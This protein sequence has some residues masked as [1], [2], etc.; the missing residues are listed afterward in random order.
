[1]V[2]TQQVSDIYIDVFSAL[3]TAVKSR[4]SKKIEWQL[5]EAGANIISCGENDDRVFFI[6]SGSAQVVNYSELGRMV[7][8]ATLTDS[9]CFG[10]L[11]AIDG[12]PRSATV[13]TKT[14]CLIGSLAGSIFID[15]VTKCDKTALKI[16][17]G[18]AKIIRIGDTHIE[19]LSLMSAE[20]K[21]CALLLA[22]INSDKKEKNKLGLDPLPT[23]NEIAANTG[24]TQNTVA[25]IFTQL[26][27]FKV[28]ER[29]RND[30]F[31]LNLSYLESVMLS[32]RLR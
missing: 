4:L 12:K 32:R 30:V 14:K 16:M 24:V 6:G 8:F 27:K 10:E 9:D 20:Q 23:Q 15:A 11:S 21:I 25:R 5:I 18:L 28:I 13:V 26:Y 1:L 3:P 7:G 22:N 19:N 31:V 29:N 17:Q 2:K